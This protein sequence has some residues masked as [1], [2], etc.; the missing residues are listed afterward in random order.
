ML[1]SECS[2]EE[3]EKL[4]LEL[5]E[6]ELLAGGYF[7]HKGASSCLGLIQMFSIFWTGSGNSISM[8]LSKISLFWLAPELPA[9]VPPS[10]VSV[11]A[12]DD[13]TPPDE[14]LK[15]NPSGAEL[16]GEY[17]IEGEDPKVRTVP[18]PPVLESQSHNDDVDAAET[19]SVTA[20]EATAEQVDEK[21]STNLGMASV[22]GLNFMVASTS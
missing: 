13:D 8:F 15:T 20:E 9:V 5:L 17:E 4:E 2:G 21:Q 12:E 3:L 6:L 10:G 11:T 7:R 22:V 16:K 19:V 14:N 18:A 1:R